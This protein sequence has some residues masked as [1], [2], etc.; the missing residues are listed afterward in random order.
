MILR[1]YQK[2]VVKSVSEHYQ[3]KRQGVIMQMATGAG[4]TKSAAYIVEKYAST[5]RQVLWLVHREE[6]LMQACMTFAE[7][8][9]NHRV[10]CAASS[11]RAIKVQ[12]FREFGKSYIHESAN[13]IVA[14]VQTLIRRLEKLDWLNPSQIIAD[15]AHLSLN[16]TFRK[17]I[18][19][20]PD[21]RLLGLTATPIR[22][23]NQS[24]AREEGGLYDEIVIGPSVRELIEL[25]NL[26]SYRVF[27]PPVHFVEGVK[28]GNKGGDYD[29]KDLEKEMDS[30]VVYGD[31]V[32]HYRNYSSGKPAIAFCPTV[33]TS[34]RLADA[35]QIAGFRA[36]SLD[37]QTDDTV[38][39]DSLRKLGAGE[40]DVITSVSILVEGTDVPYATT[41][42]MLRRTQSLA[43]YL[44]AI[45][46]VMRPHPDKEHAIILD[47]V[48][49]TMMHGLPDS[50][51]EWSLYAEE[52]SS[53][54]KKTDED[55]IKVQ[56]C[57][58]CFA[59][60]APAPICPVCGEVAP[61]KERKE[62][63]Q[64]DSDLVEIT[65]EMITVMQRQKRLAQGKAQTVADLMEQGIS[66]PRAEK[67]LEAREAKNKLI[68]DCINAGVSPGLAALRRM[69][70]KELKSLLA[71][72]QQ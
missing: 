40:L 7:I 45:G 35:F 31:A 22:T 48:G 53:K 26:A 39:R 20:Y 38:R 12:E 46:R 62:M 3:S 33:A 57:P 21:A 61:V 72:A 50:D 11:E 29:A 17:I 15:E 56:T 8:G 63:E 67:I 47:C 55:D 9:V 24:F 54:K 23:D 58:K 68:A 4:K 42:I 13:V 28:V 65:P 60:H 27:A 18:G 30:P 19:F 43:L 37:G 2:R 64:V 69:K 14:S 51:R 70:P 16:A 6:L 59:I 5:G 1:P 10:I 71:S 66:R 41:A 49:V 25:G 32:E 36:V 52:K 44:Q 34:Q